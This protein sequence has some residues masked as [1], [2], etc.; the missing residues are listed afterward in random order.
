MRREQ[1]RPLT[2]LIGDTPRVRT[3]PLPGTGRLGMVTAWFKL[4]GVAAAFVTAGIAVTAFV[5]SLGWTTTPRNPWVALLG[6]VVLTT[7]SFITARLLDQR[8]KTGALAAG[9]SFLA[10]LIPLFSN[11][12]VGTL[13]CAAA[14]IGLILLASVWRHLD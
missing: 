11:A 6:G 10:L 5:P 2:Q 12:P 7:S 4:T 13:G 9:F 3:R 14:G 1:D 8:R